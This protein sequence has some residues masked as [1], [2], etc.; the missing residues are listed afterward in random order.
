MSEGTQGKFCPLIKRECLKT[1][2][3][4]W[5]GGGE[6]YAKCVVMDIDG[7][8]FKLFKIQQLLEGGASGGSGRAPAARQRNPDKFNDDYDDLENPL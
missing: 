1:R 3:E 8:G 6:Q 7:I 4:W 2:C 5:R